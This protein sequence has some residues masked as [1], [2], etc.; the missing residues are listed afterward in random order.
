MCAQEPIYLLRGIYLF[1]FKSFFPN[2]KPFFF[3]ALVWSMFCIVVWFVWVR[4][5]AGFTDTTLPVTVSRF[6]SWPYLWFYCYY[7]IASMS[8]GIF[9]LLFCPHRWQRWS[10]LGSILIIFMMNFSV[11]IGVTL[12]AWYGP[13]YDLIQ[14]ALTQPGAVTLAEFYQG[15]FT[16]LRITLLSLTVGVFN[17]F[18][19]SHY[20]FRW[21][22][23]MN[24]FYIAHW[25]VLRHIEGASQRVQEDTMRFASTLE[26]LGIQLIQS[27]MTL[28]AF[29][30]VLATLSKHVGNLPLLGDI[31]YGL[32]IAAVAWS[33]VGTGLIAL[34]GIKLPGLEFNN[35][36]VEAA[37]RKELVYGEDH[38]DRADPL[39]AA[40]LFTAVRKNYFRL[41]FHYTYF[42]VARM[43][44]LSLDNIFSLL[45]LFPAIIAGTLTLGLITQITN[46]FDRVRYSFQYLINSW[47]TIIELL[48]IYKRLRAFESVMDKEEI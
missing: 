22:S 14:K 23:A 47:S 3:S 48:S 21:R 20:I 42:N 18:L 13:F 26:G 5:Y 4:D 28:V 34:I 15:I 33:L 2:P 32:V 17:L 19:T 43:F 39:T 29:L 44:Y 25:S 10:V 12:N 16:V 11:E 35:Q 6:V 7:L 37:Y 46:V 40:V 8:F 41:Y 24:E 9:W 38:A 30:P 1:M 45:L 31:P 27:I 36:R